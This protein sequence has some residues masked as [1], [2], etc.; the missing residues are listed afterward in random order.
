MFKMTDDIMVY[1]DPHFGH[2][3]ILDFCPDRKAVMHS[4]GFDRHDEWLLQRINS[5][6]KD[7]EALCLGDFAF[8]NLEGFISSLNARTNTIILGNHD[9]KPVSYTA[10]GMNVVQGI[11]LQFENG[12][13]YWR[14]Y[15]DPLMSAFI[16]IRKNEVVCFSHYPIL[17]NDPYTR[18]NER[19]CS[20]IDTTKEA[21]S[22]FIDPNDVVYIHGH[23]HEMKFEARNHQCVSLDQISYN[24][25]TVGE[26]IEMAIGRTN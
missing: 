9:R 18:R 22:E 24:P 25:I 8:N 6:I 3:K 19:I 17:H 13:P 10:R 21:L 7:R 20:R 4:D 15:D 12:T 26:A 1:S 16:W 23:L 11:M 14:K 5:R 2:K